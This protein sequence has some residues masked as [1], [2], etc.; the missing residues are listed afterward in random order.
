LGV[1]T[2]SRQNASAARTTTVQRL[3]VE[4]MPLL[5]LAAGA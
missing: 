2:L 1:D 5:L 4:A 3:L